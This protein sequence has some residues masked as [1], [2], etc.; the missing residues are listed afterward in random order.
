MANGAFK[1]KDNSGNVVSFISGSGSDMLFSGGTLDLSGM[2]GLT[3]GNLT[4]SGTTQNAISASHAASYLLTSSFNTYS[5]TTDTVIGTLQT[6]TSSLNSFTSSATT[7]LNSIEGVSGSYATTGS[8]LF[9]GNQT[10]SGSI[11]PA[12]DNTYDLGSV[13]NQF[14]DLYLSSASLYIDGTKVLGSTAQELQITTDT[15]QSFKI[16]EAGSDNITLQSVDGNIELKSSGGGDV[17]L[18]P[19]TGVIA[20]KGTTTLYAGNKILSSDGNAIQIGNSA[21][22]TGSLIV[23]GFIETQEL[24]TTYISSSILY[25]SGSTKFGDELSDT[26]T[27]TGSLL[28]SGTISIPGSGLISGS[29]QILNGSGVFSGSAQLPSGIVSSSAQTIANLPS[30][31][32]SGSVQVDVM[33]TT[34]IARLATTGS[35]VFTSNQIITGSITTTSNIGVGGVPSGTYGTLSVFG[36]ISIKDNNNAKLE[37]GRYS[38]GA[39]NSYIKLGANSNSLRFTNAG[40]IADIMELT[41]S[42]SLGLGVTPSAWGGSSK[43]FQ[44]GARMS[45]YNDG[46]NNAL[47]GNNTYYNGSDNYYINTAAA[48]RFYLENTGAFL[49]QQ[50]PSG[51]AGNPIT[52][53]TAMT[54]NASGNLG[55]GT[56]DTQTFR[57]AVDGPNVGQGDSTTTIR[58]FD[59][60]SATTGTGGGISF[61]GYFSGVSSIINTLS[62]IKGGKENST[63]GD[64]A[65]YLS[66]GTRINGGSPSEKLRITSGGNIGVGTSTPTNKLEIVGGNTTVGQLSVGNTD[67]TYSAGVNFLTSGTNRGFVGWRHTNSGSPF[68]LTGIHLFNTDNSNIVFG[69]NNSVKAVINVDGNLGINTTE[70]TQKLHVSGYIRTNGVSIFKTGGSIAGFIG[71]EQDWFGTGSSNN[72]IC[73]SEGGN[74]FKVFTN[75][76]TA[77]RITATTTGYVYL[78]KGWSAT[79][80]RINLEVAQ[81]NRILVVSAYAGASNDSVLI[82]AASGANYNAAANVM[83]VTTNSSTGRSISAGGTI[84]ASGNDY[85]EYMLKAVTDTISK[86]DIVGIDNEGL[87]TNIFSDSVSFVVKSTNPSYVGGDAWGTV[88]GKRP[89]RTTDQTEEEFAPILAEFEVR[90]EVERQKVDRIAFSG[91]VP[92]NLTGATVGD[93][94]IPMSTEDGKITGQAITNPS[95][96]QY[97]I[98]VGKVWKI[99]EDGRAFIAVKIG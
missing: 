98:S 60:T 77:E 96:N 44:I 46:F 37:I 66:F 85:A 79:N 19:T 3:L 10:I 25:R 6:S 99:M 9:K 4:L 63:G 64:Y 90:L 7:R 89:E 52:F 50:A 91:Q 38:S 93:Y 58:I 30:G 27:F 51:T 86:G 1:F 94:I 48:G 95:F 81:G 83:A 24:R 35:N 26:H 11:I 71:H 22:I 20:L 42:G 92:V 17:I 84:N 23:T 65:S 72:L 67:V 15:G 13:T 78:G 14:R 62:Y 76:G 69:T 49:W 29:S 43:A 80:H 56:T 57:L 82:S 70:P 40:D 68:N 21:T 36:G 75:G 54:L 2:T 73:A 5:G 31:T 47:F 12:V 55:L 41:N 45:V 97:K 8:N 18:D 88:V 59:T 28:V 32:V 53:T 16:L 87:L 34:N 33:S 61:A 74:D 39:S